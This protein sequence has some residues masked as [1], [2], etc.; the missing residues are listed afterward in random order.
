MDG[1]SGLYGT[2]PAG[3]PRVQGICCSLRKHTDAHIKHTL[4]PVS[5]RRAAAA[6]PGWLA[7]WLAG[8]EL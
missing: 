3:E 5:G 2:S 8:D 1:V 6:E 4:R 7:G